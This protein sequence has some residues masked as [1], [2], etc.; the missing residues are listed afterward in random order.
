MKTVVNWLDDRLGLSA[1]FKPLIEHRLASGW[2]DGF[3]FGASSSVPFTPS[4]V[5]RRALAA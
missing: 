2:S 5:R 3:V 1:T 4:S